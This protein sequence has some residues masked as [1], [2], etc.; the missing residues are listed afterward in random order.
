MKSKNARYIVIAAGAVAA[1]AAVACGGTPSPGTSATSAA[2]TTVAPTGTA[3]AGPEVQPAATATQVPSSIPLAEP[4][5]ASSVTGAGGT[6]SWVIEDV[7]EGAKPALALTSGGVPYIAYMRED[8]PG[9]VRNAVRNGTPWDV[10]TIAEG[11]FYGPLDIAIGSDDTAYIVYHDHQDTRF[12]PEKGDATLAI[13]TNGK[14]S[15]DALVCIVSTFGTVD[16]E[17]RSDN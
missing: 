3:P 7:D 8:M 11:Y 1:I 13:S 15:V 9:F 17:L 6:F 10:T 2:A 16:G 14:W 5:A 4:A 12:Q